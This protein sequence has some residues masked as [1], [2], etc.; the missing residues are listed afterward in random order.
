MVDVFLQIV[1]ASVGEVQTEG[2]GVVGATNT[3]GPLL[4]NLEFGTLGPSS[5][6]PTLKRDG[7]TLGPSIEQYI[8]DSVQ[9]SV[10]SIK[11]FTLN[12]GEQCTRY[13][14]R[15]VNI[16]PDVPFVIPRGSTRVIIPKIACKVGIKI[17]QSRITV[18]RA[19]KYLFAMAVENYV[20]GAV[21]AVSRA[22]DDTHTTLAELEKVKLDASQ[23]EPLENGGVLRVYLKALFPFEEMAGLN[24]G[25]HL[26]L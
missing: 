4:M 3:D 11:T 20:N 26:D 7:V 18:D 12:G 19:E 14:M 2:V 16:L 6:T 13:L 25:P 21:S 5:S 22:N 24:P 23:G 17:A 9:Q 15:L 10:Q 8:F 1:Q